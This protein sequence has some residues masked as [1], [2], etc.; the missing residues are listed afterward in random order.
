MVV[1]FLHSRKISRVL[2]I[3]VVGGVAI[4]DRITQAVKKSSAGFWLSASASAY[5]R[6]IMRVGTGRGVK[7]RRFMWCPVRRLRNQK[8]P[9]RF[10]IGLRHIAGSVRDCVEFRGKFFCVPWR[11]HRIRFFSV[12]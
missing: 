7:V 11:M 5:M 1:V 9:W 3:V 6:S 2:S 8:E 4:W 12:Y 10:T